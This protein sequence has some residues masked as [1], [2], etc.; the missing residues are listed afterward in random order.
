MEQFG[1][2]QSGTKISG[3]AMEIGINKVLLNFRHGLKDELGS[4]YSTGPRHFGRVHLI[5]RVQRATTLI[6]IKK[7]NCILKMSTKKSI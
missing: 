7:K 6:K 5:L 2:I 4:G 3:R 1:L